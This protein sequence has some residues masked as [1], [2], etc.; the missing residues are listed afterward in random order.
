[1][2]DIFADSSWMGAT[3]YY[4]DDRIEQRAEDG[5]PRKRHLMAPDDCRGLMLDS[6]ESDSSSLGKDWPFAYRAIMVVTHLFTLYRTLNGPGL[7]QHP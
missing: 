6:R 3:A 2:V 5:S 4:R 7:R 1:M